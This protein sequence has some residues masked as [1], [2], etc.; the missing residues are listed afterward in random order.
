MKNIFIKSFV[1]TALLSAVMAS[2]AS[3]QDLTSYFV[4]GSVERNQHNAA[5]APDRGYVNI[6]VLG[7]VSMSV[8]GNVSL[9]Q[10]LFTMDGDLVP[11][12]DTRVS[13][14]DALAGLNSTNTFGLSNRL[15]IL[16]FGSY[17]RDRKSFWSFDLALRSSVNGSLPYEFFEFFKMAPDYST[18]KD[19]NL[20]MDSYVEAAFGYSRKLGILGDRLTVGA[21][22]KFLAGL[23]QA[24]FN[25]DQMDISLTGD[26][27]VAKAQGS[28]NFNAAGMSFEQSVG[29]DGQMIYDLDSMDGSFS[30]PAGYGAAIDLGAT[31]DFSD[32]LR[33]SLALNDV[34]FI[35]WSKSSNTSATI[36]NE[37]SFSGASLDVNSGS[38]DNT[39]D[40]VEIDEIE[41]VAEESEAST[42]WL[43]A[44]VKAGAEYGFFNNRIGI[45]GI[46][47]MYLWSSKTIHNITAA[48]TLRP[49]RWFS[50]ASSYAFTNN[51]SNTLGFAANFATGFVNLYIA[52]DLLASR[53]TAQYIPIE[54]TSMNASFGLAIPLGVRG[55]RY[56]W[57]K[58]GYDNSNYNESGI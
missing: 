16:G 51:R 3:A 15:S 4:T 7:A 43:Q 32:R 17:M 42:K 53:K 6:P 38:V 35:S 12:F 41:F 45:G 13:A 56:S 28:M 31:F 39:T 49:T 22:F 30:G 50:F 1:A 8:S 29:E 24:N 55:E 52:T 54:Q 33:F 20:Y 25:I 2:T 19:V 23:F 44:N 27:W 18:I 9:D 36:A 10:M 47:S 5:F 37:F 48:V 58:R 46:Y 57:G 34:G 14:S 26:E 21:R 40:G 11:I